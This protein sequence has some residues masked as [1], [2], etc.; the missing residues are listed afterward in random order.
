MW[1]AKQDAQ[2]VLGLLYDGRG[3]HISRGELAARAVLDDSRLDAAMALC[4]D[5][6]H[7]IAS[8]AGLGLAL[9]EPIRLDAWLIERGLGVERIGRDVICFDQVESTN[10]VAFG[11]AR[12]GG[13]DGLV[14]MAEFQTGGRGR[15]GRRWVSPPGANV[16]MSA[17]LIDGAPP[18]PRGAVTIAAGLAVAEAIEVV[19]PLTTELKWPNDVLIDGGK[20]AGVLV[21]SR[22]IAAAGGSAGGSAVVIGIGINANESPPAELVTA[23]AASLAGQLAGP[24]DRIALARSVIRRLDYWLARVE[25]GQLD[26]LRAGWRARCGMIGRRIRVRCGRRVHV[27]RVLDVSPLDELVIADDGGARINLPANASTVLP[28]Y[29]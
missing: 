27:G 22:G 3:S 13:A 18:L 14:V 12:Q 23:P 2:R 5:R 4:R 20:V 10:D 21:E 17:L 11:S 6:G 26:A 24:V 28:D 9:A 7:A 25:A 15:M 19:C 8:A 16:L 1:D 29:G